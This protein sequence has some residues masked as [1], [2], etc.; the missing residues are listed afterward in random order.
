MSV[1]PFARGGFLGASN[2][3]GPVG[4]I[5]APVERGELR[6]EPL[7]DGTAHLRDCA[8]GGERKGGGES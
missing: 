6:F 2:D 7:A 1:D 8:G 3:L 4:V 5:I